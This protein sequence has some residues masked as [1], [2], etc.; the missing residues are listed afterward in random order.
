MTADTAGNPAR[1]ARPGRRR[2]RAAA[3]RAAAPEAIAVARD[4]AQ[5]G[6][7]AQAVDIASSALA[8]AKSDADASLALLE[9]RAESLVAQ[10][11]V[12]RALA[13]AKA[14]LAIAESSGRPSL[15]AQALNCLSRV[16][17]S[18]G[19]IDAAVT[20]AAQALKAARRSRRKPL[21]AT[22]LLNLAAAQTRMRQSTTGVENA[23]AA[24]RHFATL[25]DEMR[26]GRALWV[27]ACA[28]DD[29]GHKEDSERAADEALAIARRCGDA[30]GEASALNIRWR[31]HIDLA[32]R[33]RGLHLS[34]ACYR[35]SGHVS[36]QA[37]IYN[38]L[39]LAYRALG[40]YRRSSRMAHRSIEIRRRIHDHSSVVNGMT[41]LAGNEFLS[42]NA[43]TARKYL[44]E[45][46]AAGSL[47][48]AKSDGTW[49]LAMDWLSGMIAILEHDGTAAVPFLG[50]AL[51]RVQPMPETSFQ[52]LVLTDLC[53]AHLLAGE[54][55]AAL[56]ASR[57]AVDLYG[58]RERRAIGAG[59][60]PAHVWWWHY[61]ALA[62]HGATKEAQIALQNAYGLLLEGIGTLSDEGLRRS[63]LNKIDSH[64]AIVR[65]W[66][67]HARR[68]RLSASRRAAHLAGEADLRAPFERLVDTGMR[69]NELRSAE[70]LHEFLVDEVTELSGAER[71]L[72]VLDTP[73]RTAGRLLAPARGRRRRRA[74]RRRSSPWL[75]D[76][77]RTRVTEPALSPRRGGRDRAALVPRRAA[78]RATATAGLSL[79]GHRRRLR[80]LPRHRPRSPGHAGRAGRGRARQ[81]AVVA[82][83]SNRRSRSA[84]W[85]WKRPTRCRTAREELA[86][87]NS[88]QQAVGAALDFQAIVDTVG[89]KLREVFATGDMT[90]RWWDEGTRLD[91]RLYCYEHGVRLQIPPRV[92][93]PDGL[94]ARFYRE[95][96]VW[97]FNSQAEQAALGITALP[98]T[99]QARSI[100]SV[101]MMAGERIFGAVM[102]EDH[103]RDNAF[104]PAEVRL[105]ETITAS[106]AVAL[107][108]ARSYEAE[109]Q[110]AAELAVISAVQQALAGEL[111]IQGVYDAVGD[112]LSE[113]FRRSS[114]GIR[115]YDAGDGR[116]AAIR[117]SPTTTSVASSPPQPRETRAL[118]RMSCAPAR[119]CVINEDMD[120]AQSAL[121][122]PD[123]GRRVAEPGRR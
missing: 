3:P 29:L 52:I 51:R 18:S 78:D 25:G 74:D 41:I 114:V 11:E 87:I 13:D 20:T 103:E 98:G 45:I 66:I 61:R 32:K 101:P 83:A 49:A 102:L 116:R 30:W 70:E 115:T 38:N 77:R 28:Q 55:E 9:L 43:A 94:V 42:G 54:P 93:E 16:H 109:R 53:A 12:D 47:P 5:A 76:A 111:S 110:R 62:A 63:Y 75:D 86:I 57:R 50:S 21:I 37:A 59:I 34:L 23:S 120:G 56:E 35:A 80:P 26:R 113:V 22:C 46:G 71:V 69:L 100:V 68:R 31:Q 84:P 123:L 104:G 17:L 1:A 89:D 88:I 82:R 60:S 4:L 81:R 99:D 96:K 27:I 85:S 10:G 6:Q 108:N 48:G 2:A 79:R 90:I 91:T 106:M 122:R 97:L 95:R 14:M 36:G 67:E 39:A 112:K 73:E 118:A 105:L 19:G 107:L 65:A 119:R 44:T 40:L 58:A 72:L 64:R 7:H 92:V 33:L 15:Q 8:H 24:A 117:I 121:R